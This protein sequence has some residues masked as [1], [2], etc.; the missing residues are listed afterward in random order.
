MSEYDFEIKG[1]LRAQELRIHALA[2]ATVEREGETAELDRRGVGGD[3][4][5]GET[6]ENVEVERTVRGRVRNRV[7]E[8]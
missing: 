4:R 7:Q 3:L 6:Y 2:D 8:R 5:A 1:F